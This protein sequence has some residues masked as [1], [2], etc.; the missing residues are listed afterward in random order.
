M[1]D[2]LVVDGY[3]IINA[4]PSMERLREESFAHAR[5]ILIKILENYQA[6][7]GNQVIVVFDAHRVKGSVEKKEYIGRVQVIYTRENETA[8][9]VIE[10]MVSQLPKTIM[11]TV[12][13]SDWAEQRMVLGQ[14]ALRLSARELYEEVMETERAA[15]EYFISGQDNRP[16]Y[17]RMNEDVRL[18]LEKWRRKK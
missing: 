2:I 14:G 13:T 10:K 18:I 8:D 7:K 5:E 6:L 4:W 17:T 12:A 3:N 15:Q 16:I 1:E 11:I 9:M